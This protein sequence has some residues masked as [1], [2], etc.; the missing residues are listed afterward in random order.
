MMNLPN[1]VFELCNALEKEARENPVNREA[2]YTAAKL[3]RVFNELFD[4]SLR[5]VEW[6]EQMIKDR[7]ADAANGHPWNGYESKYRGGKRK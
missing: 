7:E 5:D 6:A 4:I 3:L 2:H 1:Y